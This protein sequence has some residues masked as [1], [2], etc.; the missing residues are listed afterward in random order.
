MALKGELAIVSQ[1]ISVSQSFLQRLGESPCA[2]RAARVILGLAAAF[3]VMGQEA[4]PQALNR[5]K[6]VKFLPVSC[7]FAVAQS[8]N[9]GRL[10]ILKNCI[11]FF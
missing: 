7:I 2:P 3:S 1:S 4:L 9:A 5:R 6:I 8:F 10:N 11:F